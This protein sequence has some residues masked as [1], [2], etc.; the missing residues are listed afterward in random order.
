MRVRGQATDRGAESGYHSPGWLAYEACYSLRLRIAARTA[1]GRAR[2]GAL[3]ADTTWKGE[4]AMRDT[5][6]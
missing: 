2:R 6:T 1:G 4:F 5:W 3:P